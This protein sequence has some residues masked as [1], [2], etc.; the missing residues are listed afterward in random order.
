MSLTTDSK[1]SSSINT[2]LPANPGYPQDLELETLFQD[3][4]Q[5]AHVLSQEISNGSRFIAIALENIT[6]GDY[7]SVTNSGGVCKVQKANA[8]NNTKVAI[9]FSPIDATAGDWGAYI[10]LGNNYYLTGLTPGVMY[11]LSDVT[12]GG[13]ITTKPVGAGKIVQTLGFSISAT[14]LITNIALQF[15]QL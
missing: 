12:G 9:G 6:A 2:N 15:T 3:V 14:E 7:I 11:Y 13:A 10:T 4:Y 8:T 5:A 1:V